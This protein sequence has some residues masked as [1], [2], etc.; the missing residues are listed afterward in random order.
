M[1]ADKAGKTTRRDFLRKI[2]EEI[3][4]V[5]AAKNVFEAE[6]D[7][8]R[9]KY[10]LTFP[11]PYMNG[12]LHLGHAFSFSKCE[13]TAR[14]QRMA[15]KNVLLPFG[16]HCTGM[17]IPACADKLRKELPTIDK[18]NPT[19]QY[20]ILKEMNVAESEIPEFVD[21]H[22]WLKYFPPIAKQDLINFGVAVDW[23]RSFIT[24]PANPYYDSF[25]Q[26]HFSHL[27]DQGKVK[28]G[29]KYVIY[30]TQQ[31]QPCSDHE[32]AK[33]EGVKPQEYTLIKLQVQQPFP[34]ELQS[35]EAS[36]V[37]LVAATLRPETMYGQTNCYVLPTG[38]YGA[39][40]MKNGEVFIC[41]ERSV[42]NMA[43]QELTSV[44]GQY[45]KIMDVAGSVLL[46]ARLSAPLSKYPTVYALPM[47]SI[48]MTKGTGIV[49]SVPSDSPDDYAAL[50]DLQKKP[51]FRE[52]YGIT[53]EMVNFEIVPIIDIPGIG[54]KAAV[55]LFEQLGIKSQNDRDLLD[56]AKDLAYTKGFSHGVMIVGACAGQKVSVAKN[57]IR[58]ELIDLNLAVVYYEPE[59][60]V[61]SR[62]GE[63]CVVA[64][65]DQWFLAYD[66]ENWRKSVA[67]H[68]STNFQ[69]Y[70]Q[71]V[72]KEFEDTV[73][74]LGEWACSRQYGL[75]SKLAVDP[76]YVIESLSDSTI[77][78][79]YYSIAHWLQGGVLDGSHKGP[80]GLEASALGRE[81]FDYVFAQTDVAPQGY[82][83]EVLDKMR[84]E[85]LYWYPMDLRCSG[86]D[87]IRNHLTMSLFNHAA[88]WRNRP[89]LWPRSFFC[90]GHIRL[91][92][93]KMSKGEGNFLTLAGAIEKYGADA[94]RMAIADAGDTIDDANFTDLLANTAILKLYSFHEWIVDSI[95]SIGNFRTGEKSFFDE[96]F[97][98]EINNAIEKTR[99]AYESMSFREALVGGFFELTSKKEEY[100]IFS[101]TFHR[102]IFFRYLSV[103]LLLLSPIAPHFCEKYWELYQEALSIPRS[104]I[105]NEPFPTVSAPVSLICLRQ[106]S[107]IR[108]I[109]KIAR[110]SQEKSAKKQKKAPKKVTV[111]ISPDYPVDLQ[112]ILTVL[113]NYYSTTPNPDGKEYINIIKKMNLDK[114]AT[115]KMMQF[116]SFT[117]GE[118]KER[119]LEAFELKVP[120]DEA[121]ILHNLTPYVLQELALE[122]LKIEGKH[123]GNDNQQL[124][125][126]ALPGKPQFFFYDFR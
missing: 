36:A 34:A 37:Y 75:G 28:F 30:A 97:E 46:G 74:W 103:Q 1:A 121:V 59:G 90:N 55:T 92:N 87:L 99:A 78:M 114:S 120:F 79:A 102:D 60:E 96:I 68:I 73:N 35:L 110:V 65:C 62:S 80:A 109:L 9:P 86:K 117:I 115:Q 91:D 38:T 3:Q 4:A 84:N 40:R 58:K 45:E 33:G 52:K 116:A 83:K 10:F 76:Q 124:R 39:F 31:G 123:E 17:P 11:Y 48:S 23:R 111:Y 101:G 8:S 47:L 24:T 77:Y 44:F 125:D 32:R 118:Y 5:W 104:L 81:F 64:L 16:F 113:Y 12:C 70:S 53:E 72:H 119:G 25:I 22:Y 27:I 15:G 43:Y 85:F 13:F 105:V 100:R 6:P 56:K 49:T 41:S 42:R 94:T 107:Y 66:D 126:A 57:L 106:M 61:V 67:E 89:D 98:N 54:D 88:V 93:K 29:K 112:N 20:K 95:N 7:L 2:E 82:D 50:T 14:Y 122:E 26:W 21:A 18:S 108:S 69:A 63:S 51:A 71:I 19:G